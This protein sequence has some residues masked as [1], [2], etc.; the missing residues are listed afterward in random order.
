MANARN[1]CKQQNTRLA[2]HWARAASAEKTAIA[3]LGFHH[4]KL[5]PA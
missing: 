2:H 4:E 5:S 1:G 3:D